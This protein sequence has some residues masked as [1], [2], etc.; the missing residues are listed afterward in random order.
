MMH[1][2]VCASQDWR[3]VDRVVV[4]NFVIASQA[5]RKWYTNVISKISNGNYKLERYAFFVFSY[6]FCRVI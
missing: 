3:K 5:L 2:A 1:L 6:L 4:G